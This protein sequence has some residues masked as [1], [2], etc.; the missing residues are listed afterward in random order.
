[1]IRG[2]SGSD[3]FVDRLVLCC[4]LL[5]ACSVNSLIVIPLNV[6]YCT[7]HSIYL[8]LSDYVSLLRY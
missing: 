8:S 1:M 4:R 2:H 7:L 5:L 3:L 6:G